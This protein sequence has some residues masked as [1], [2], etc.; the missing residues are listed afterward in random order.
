MN[1]YHASS[2]AK[3]PLPPLTRST[4]HIRFIAA[5]I[6]PADINQIQGTYPVKPQFRDGL[7]AVGG[8]EGLA[9]VIAAGDDVTDLK[10]GDWVIPPASGFGT[11]RTHASCKPDELLKLNKHGISPLIAATIS[12]NPCTAY[13]ML[14]DFA[15]LKPGDVV[16]QNGG[17]SGVGQSVIQLAKAWN[18]KTVNVIRN[19]PNFDEIAENLQDIGADMVISEEDARKPEIAAKVKNLGP[20]SRLALNCVGGKSATNIARLLGH[21][22][23]LVTYGGMSKEPLILPTSL[24]IFKNLTSQG[25]WMT[26]WYET[27]SKAERAAMLDELFQLAQAGKL[28]EPWHDKTSLRDAPNMQDAAL[29]SIHKATSGF[30]GGKQ[31]FVMD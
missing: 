23:H 30:S 3:V 10:V 4:V 14:R 31:I 15:S 19:R 26:R 24:F 21:D 9:E 12:V 18:I 6:N 22:G 2:I 5:P 7:G 29:A 17:N 11:W 13:R 20:S 8:N 27:H 1:L 28:R 16:I 25:F